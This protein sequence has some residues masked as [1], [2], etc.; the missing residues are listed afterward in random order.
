MHEIE[1]DVGNNRLYVT[2][3]GKVDEDEAAASA[4]ETIE[5]TKRLDSGFGVVTGERTTRSRRPTR[6]GGR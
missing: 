3:V 1:A 2:V 5:A 6:H 4:E